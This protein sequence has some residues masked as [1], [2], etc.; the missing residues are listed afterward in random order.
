MITDFSLIDTQ[1]DFTHFIE[2]IRT[3]SPNYIALD[4]EFVRVSTYWPTLALVQ[5]AYGETRVAIDPLA[6][7]LNPF[8]EI[9]EN[10]SILKI[11]HASQQ[12]L[13]IF[14]RVFGSLPSSVF[15]TQIAAQ[16]C[17]FG[18]SIA[19]DALVQAYCQ[20]TLDKSSQFTNWK[21]RPLS[22]KQLRYAINDV[23]YLQA[24]YQQLVEALKEK[25]Y[26]E[27]A[28]EEMESLGDPNLY[29][30]D[31]ETVWRRLKI[32][33]HNGAFLARLQAVSIVREKIAMQ[34]NKPRS[35]IV[36]DE[37]II[38]L[39]QKNTVSLD[40]VMKLTTLDEEE[41]VL[42]LEALREAAALSPEAYPSLPKMIKLSKLLK[43][44]VQ[45]LKSHLLKISQET[46]ISAS[47]IAK[48]R[49]L[50]AFVRHP[51]KNYR[52]LKGWRYEIFGHH[53][54]KEV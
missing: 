47:L 11:I 22:K 36:K 3:Q 9:L 32:I 17:G 14:L 54:L 19:Y 27:W 33:S 16:F 18:D 23:R 10:S 37:L 38:Q 43:E 25:K 30:Q 29:Q 35:H 1:R 7:T 48:S 12:D 21:R 24:I 49:E 52:F 39:A 2:A 44:K 45:N 6:I 50:E 41:S 51:G 28:L 5:L 20:V 26:Y 46:G 4:T 15:D 13:E 8:Q 34:K 40:K 42:F 53:A 31:L